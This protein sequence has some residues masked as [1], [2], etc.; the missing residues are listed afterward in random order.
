MSTVKWLD[1]RQIRT[2]AV[3]VCGKMST[4]RGQASRDMLVFSLGGGMFNYTQWHGQSSLLHKQGT[5]EFNTTYVTRRKPLWLI[6]LKLLGVAAMIAVGFGLLMPTLLHFDFSLWQAAAIAAGLMLV[7]AGVAFFV[8]PEPNTDNLGGGVCG[9]TDDPYQYS[10]NVNRNLW[11]AHCLLGPGRF[12]A[13]T[14]LDTCVVLGLA[15][16]RSDR[17]FR[18]AAGRNESGS[19]GCDPEAPRPCKKRLRRRTAH[20][21]LPIRRRHIQG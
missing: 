12:T 3:N 4:C 19:H 14:F 5:V 2:A 1:S 9:M 20:Q 21:R 17:G 7:Y 15:R 18:P 13:E 10:D 11:T 8:R 16:R 6:A